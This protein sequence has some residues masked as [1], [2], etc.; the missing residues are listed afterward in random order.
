[1]LKNREI[2]V[3]LAKTDE[4]SEETTIVE[5]QPLLS[6]TE[7]HEIKDFALK[8]ALTVTGCF[9]ALKVVDAACEIT[10]AHASPKEK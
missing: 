2:R 10:V 4:P 9:A 3:R 8:A 6:K 7:I 1:M 5:R